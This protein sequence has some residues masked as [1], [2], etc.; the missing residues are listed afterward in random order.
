MI[1][2]SKRFTFLEKRRHENSKIAVI[3]YGT[4]SRV[5]LKAVVEA[6]REGIS[7]DYLR[8]ITVWPFPYDEVLKMAENV[9]HILVPELNAG[10]IYHSVAEAVR[11]EA[12]VLLVMG[13]ARQFTPREILDEIKKLV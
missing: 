13:I 5:A 10:Q 7:V 1:K 2:N 3:S 11:G 4:V 6:K 9:D 12:A 8:L